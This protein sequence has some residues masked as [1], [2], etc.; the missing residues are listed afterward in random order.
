[1]RW[2]SAATIIATQGTA[3]S[4]VT[5]ERILLHLSARAL[6]LGI[7]TVTKLRIVVSYHPLLPVVASCRDDFPSQRMHRIR[8]RVCGRLN[9]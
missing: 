7:T 1:M 8:M 3:G 2:H 5:Y 6:L 4:Q 9:D